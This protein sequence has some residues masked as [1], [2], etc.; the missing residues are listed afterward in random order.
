MVIMISYRLFI[1]NSIF[2]F[3]TASVLL[4]VLQKNIVSILDFGI[5]FLTLS[6]GFLLNKLIVFN[7]NI[8]KQSIYYLTF[9]VYILFN[10]VFFSF[11]RVFELKIDFFDIFLTNIF[12]FKVWII[13][14]FLFMIYFL[15]KDI[16][17]DKFEIFIILLLKIG[18]VYTFIEQ[19]ISL[20]GGRVLFETIYSRAGIVTENLLGLKSLGLYRIW[21]VIGSTQLLGMYHLILVS[22]YMFGKRTSN[23]WL[24]MSII[25]VVLSTSKTAYVI[26]LL[27]LLIYLIVKRKYFLLS[28]ITIPLLFGTVYLITHLD[29]NFIESFLN[30]FYILIGKLKAD[31]E[32]SVYEQVLMNFNQYSFLIGQGM[33]YSYAGIEQLPI[34]LK[35]YYYL[36]ADFSFLSFI[37]QFGIVGYLLFSFVF[38][39]YPINNFI[40]NKN[41]EHNMNLIILWLGTFHYPVFIS[42]LIMLYI[43]YS[44]YIVYFK[45]KEQNNWKI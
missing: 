5:L 28:M 23:F 21:G 31:N 32:I 12:E 2:L 39:F 4:R 9:L 16:D 38:C 26:L 15:L 27:M 8:T 25:G 18:L 24:I 34:E 17:K 6:I 7:N 11:Y 43:S 40:K 42:K 33:N 37:N 14:F 36:S 10:I 41:R 19:F 29:K 45:N 22:Y 13:S 44:I 3:F 35:K 30:F 1:L 20:F